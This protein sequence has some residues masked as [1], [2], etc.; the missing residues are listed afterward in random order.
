M[1]F[2]KGHKDAFKKGNIPWNKG[3]KGVQIPSE[4]TKQKIS[5]AHKGRTPWNKGQSKYQTE[6]E[7]K[8]AKKEA[9]QKY[10]AAN[11]EEINRRKKEKYTMNKEEERR[12]QR[13]RY[14]KRK[15]R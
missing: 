4:E 10:E 13:E 2:K 9:R 6:D 12:K 15:K 1:A 3:K 8:K 7:L 11:R 14:Q 5:N